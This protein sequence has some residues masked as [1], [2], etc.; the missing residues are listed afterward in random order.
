MRCPISVSAPRARSATADSP[1]EICA[2][3]R[4]VDPLNEFHKE[5][6]G[7]FTSLLDDVAE[8]SAESFSTIAI[9]ADGA[10]LAAAGLNRPT[11]TWTYLVHDNPFG[12]DIDRAIRSVGRWLRGKVR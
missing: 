7:S 2:L 3:A 9:T 6:V 5:A 8:R 11:A 4:A 1:T 12:P 10:D